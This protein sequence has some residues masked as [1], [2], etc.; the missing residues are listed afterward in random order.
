[1]KNIRIP[2]LPAL[3]E[4]KLHQAGALMETQASRS[5]IDVVNWNEFPYKPVAAFDIARGD[6][7]L[8]IR[9]FVKGMSLKALCEADGSPVYTDSCVEFFMQRP[10]E[11]IYRNFEFNCIGVCDASR[12]VSR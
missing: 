4:L 8:F 2:Y 12:R 7:S 10:G 6:A 5:Y 3:N 9:F 11:D 1:M